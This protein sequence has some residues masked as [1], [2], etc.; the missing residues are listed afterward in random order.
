MEQRGHVQGTWQSKTSSQQLMGWKA[1][2]LVAVPHLKS[3]CPVFWDAGDGKG[4]QGTLL[5]LV[6]AGA[7]APG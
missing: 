1:Q 6:T 4:K 2:I 7:E 5:Y 3:F